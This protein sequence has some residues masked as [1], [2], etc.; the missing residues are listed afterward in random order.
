MQQ[1]FRNVYFCKKKISLPNFLLIHFCLLF[2][3]LIF[4]ECRQILWRSSLLFWEPLPR[5]VCSMS[6]RLTG[7]FVIFLYMSLLSS[8]FSFLRHG[9]TIIVLFQEEG[10]L[11]GRVCHRIWQAGR[12]QSSFCGGELAVLISCIVRAIAFLNF[13]LSI[14]DIHPATFAMV[15]TEHLKYL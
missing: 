4:Q 12:N 15:K 11:T 13:R 3:I 6:K 10:S 1:I 7:Y 5:R 9:S 8:H 14:E 2:F